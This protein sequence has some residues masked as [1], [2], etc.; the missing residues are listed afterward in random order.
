[1]SMPE[2]LPDD[3]MPELSSACRDRP[4][5]LPPLAIQE[6]TKGRVTTYIY[7]AAPGAV[8]RRS[9]ADVELIVND[10]LRVRVPAGFDPE[11]L[12]QVLRI[13]KVHPQPESH[14]S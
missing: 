2:P 12:R 11:S 10:Q 9:G 7:H 3:D 13:L 14:V 5:I 4:E 1:M 6:D 8:P